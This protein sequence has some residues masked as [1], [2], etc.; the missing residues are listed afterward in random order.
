[1]AWTLN[2]SSVL[3][4]FIKA[5]KEFIVGTRVVRTAVAAIPVSATN[6][7]TMDCSLADIFTYTP[8][9]ATT[10]TPTNLAPGQRITI[11]FLTVGTSSFV[12]T[13]GA[14]FKTTGTLATGTTAARYFI[15][16]FVA[17]PTGTILVESSRTAAI[18]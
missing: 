1:M 14:P 15:L 2:P 6:A 12:V 8:T 11:V 10:I 4:N 3:R 5:A 17:D 13:F 7:T 16:E 18:A 9:E